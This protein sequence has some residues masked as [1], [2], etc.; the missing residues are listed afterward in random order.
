MG[1]NSIGF[2]K[3]A[4]YNV[5]FCD[6]AQRKNQTGTFDNQQKCSSKKY[7]IIHFKQLEYQVLSLQK[8][9]NFL[10]KLHFGL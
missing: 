9:F 8:R 4:Q 7:Y 1:S 2:L 3:Y 6:G 5:E 10:P